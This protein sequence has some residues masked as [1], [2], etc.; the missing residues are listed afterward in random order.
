MIS[1]RLGVGDFGVA[2]AVEGAE[3]GDVEGVEGAGFGFA[4]GDEVEV[5]EDGAAANAAG[6]GVAHGAEGF[7]GG[8]AGDGES[9]DEVVFEEFGG[10]LGFDAEGFAAAGQGAE[11][12]GDP[13]SVHDAGLG[14]D[15]GARG[16]VA[17]LGIDHGGDQHRGVDGGGHG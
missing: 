6:F 15:E 17:E 10:E 9:G 1:I 8:E 3:V 4:G 7:G 14:G 5:V 12:F 13:V 16:G 2:G 11:G